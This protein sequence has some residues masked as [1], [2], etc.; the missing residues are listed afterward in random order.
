MH[1][2]GY[3]NL[4]GAVAL[5]LTAAGMAANA[6]PRGRGAAPHITVG[7]G[8]GPGFWFN[9][10]PVSFD[11]AVHGGVE[12]P[13]ADRL[14]LRAL[15]PIQFTFSG[16]ET[17]GIEVD[18]FGFAV[19]PRMEAAIQLVPNLAL[20]VGAGVGP[21]YFRN[22]VKFPGGEETFTDTRVEIDLLAGMEY[23]LSGRVSIFVDPVRLRIL[24]NADPNRFRVE[25]V[26]LTSPPTSVAW[27]LLAGAA[28]RL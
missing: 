18:N 13:L 9:D 10:A 28:L 4:F 2:S 8:A 5:L 12:F 1:R 23:Q 26:I 25:S 24:P 7:V 11:L 22:T 27:T 21:A 16:D 15:L 17:F 14:A 3:W 19:V 6:Q 20:R